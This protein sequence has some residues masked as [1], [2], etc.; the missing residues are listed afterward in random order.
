M[1]TPFAV[2]SESSSRTTSPASRRS[3][4]ARRVLITFLRSFLAVMMT[5]EFYNLYDGLDEPTTIYTSDEETVKRHERILELRKR[6]NVSEETGNNGEPV[7][8]KKRV[9]VFAVAEDT[10]T[11]PQE[12]GDSQP[13][14]PNSRRLIRPAV[15]FEP[16]QLSRHLPRRRSA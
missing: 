12:A 9:S 5:F 1:G 6:N 13:D 7:A 3:S 11:S 16:L 15:A 8:K 10:G 2:S 14:R 4:A